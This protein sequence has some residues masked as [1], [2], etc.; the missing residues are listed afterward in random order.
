MVPSSNKCTRFLSVNFSFKH[1]KSDKL[2]VVISCVCLRMRLD[3]IENTF[4][5][6]PTFSNQ[7]IQ[8][9][10]TCNCSDLSM[11][12]PIFSWILSGFDDPTDGIFQKCTRLYFR[13]PN[14]KFA[15]G[16]GLRAL[17]ALTYLRLQGREEQTREHL[18]YLCIIEYIT[19]KIFSATSASNGSLIEW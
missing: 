7:F 18:L 17:N 2:R 9:V 16:A 10:T 1:P 13:H 11:F 6:Y 12:S 4:W 14:W 15:L 3:T 5:D 19:F 8:G